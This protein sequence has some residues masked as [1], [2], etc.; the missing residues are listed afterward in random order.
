MGV[1]VEIV[2]LALLAILSTMPVLRLG[3]IQAVEIA[4]VICLSAA[5]PVFVYRGLKIPLGGLWRRYGSKYLLFLGLCM[6][7]SVLSL[8]LPFHPPPDIIW[9]KRPGLL[10]LSRIFELFLVSY[11]MLAIAETLRR[12]PAL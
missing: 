9:L 12:R 6:V 3:D 10:S 11:F 1:A 8:R 5:A 7:V 4:Q 2:K